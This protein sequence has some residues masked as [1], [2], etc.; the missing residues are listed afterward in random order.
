VRQNLFEVFSETNS[1]T[2]KRRS[3][4][5]PCTRHKVERWSCARCDRWFALRGEEIFFAVLAETLQK[6]LQGN[7]PSND[8][9]ALLVHAA[10]SA[11]TESLDDFVAASLK[12]RAH[13]EPQQVE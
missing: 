6:R 4:G 12:R 10:G 1:I 2:R 5:Y 8:G 3:A 13:A 7:R 11:A 9:I